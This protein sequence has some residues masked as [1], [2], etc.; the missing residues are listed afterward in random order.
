ME[1]PTPVSSLLHSSTMVVARVYLM[2]LMPSKLPMILRVLLLASNMVGQMDVKKNIAYSTSI[3]LMIMVLLSVS[4]I[5]S[6]VIVYIMVHGIVK[7][8]LFQSSGYEIHS[9]GSQDMRKFS[10]KGRTII[11]LFAIFILSAL[12]GMVML[13]SKELIV[14]EGM[15]VLILMLVRVSFFYT[16]IYGNKLSVICGVGE[17]ERFYVYLIILASMMVVCVNLE[18]WLGFVIIGVVLMSFYRN[19]MV[20]VL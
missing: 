20:T 6:I 3:H 9:L 16:I 13:G 18:S 8:Q 10:L 14:L 2:M 4:E 5:Y 19:S 7:G 12:V 15:T 11:M 1:G 17:R